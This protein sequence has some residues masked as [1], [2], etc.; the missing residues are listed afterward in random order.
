MA[1]K[2][3]ELTEKPEKYAESLALVRAK[4]IGRPTTYNQEIVDYILWEMT[5]NGTDLANA[6]KKIKFPKST[7]YYWAATNADFSAALDEARQ[8]VADHCAFQIIN[9]SNEIEDPM[10]DRIRLD[11]LK[12]IAGRYHPKMYSEK[13]SMALT[14]ANGGPVQLQAVQS[15][16]VENL[17][18]EHR[19]AF[20]RALIA[21]S[22]AAGEDV[23]EY[24]D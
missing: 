3:T 24:E 2:K 21:A 4:K 7:V 22:K 23:S 14:G 12:W 6:C 1:K 10:K 13:G 20:K 8:A 17:S 19:E 11:A 16:P 15:V 18:E 5:E 9:L